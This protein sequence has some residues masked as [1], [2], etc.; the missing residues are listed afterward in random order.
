VDESVNSSFKVAT[1][2]NYQQALDWVKAP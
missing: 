2:E 1:F